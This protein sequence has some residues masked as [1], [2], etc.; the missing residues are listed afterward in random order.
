MTLH[1]HRATRTDVLADALAELLA[2]PL[3][4]PFAEEVVV[5]PAKGVERWLTQ[6]LS[7]RLGAGP[8]GSDGVCAGVRFLNPRSLVA[9]LTGTERDDPWDPD[10]SVW[11]L[12]SVIDASL[13]EP[14]CALLAR[15]LGHG[16][17]GEQG[18]LRRN[19]RYS[20]ARRIAGLFASYALQ[21][22]QLLV[23]WREGRDTD[24]AGKPL[25]E[26]LAWQ[27][28]L[29][30]RLLQEYDDG[31][32]AGPPD[33]RHRRAVDAI[34]AGNDLALPSRLSMFGH[35][36]MATTELALLRAVGE[37]R[38]V[39]L[40]LPQPSPEGWRRVAAETEDGPVRRRDDHSG[41][42][43]AHPLLA[44]LGRD[45][46]ELRRSIP[47]LGPLRDDELSTPDGPAVTLLA[48]LQDQ[49]RRDEVGA[50]PGPPDD[51]VQ[52]HA[53][54]GPGRQVE[55]LR[56]VLVGLL[57]DDPTLEPRDI[58][59]M[60]P[61][62]EAYAP[63]FSAAFGLAEAAG[64]GG[65]PGHQL[66]VRLADRGLA[67]TNPL[68]ALA[69]ALVRIA[70]GRATASEVLDLAGTAPVR[71]RFGI[72]DD[73]LA[74]LTGWVERSGVRW[75]LTADLRAPYG[76]EG[77]EENTWAL[78]LDR[79]LLGAATAEDGTVL[80]GRL[81]L[82]DVGSSSIDLAGRLAELVDRLEDGVVALR[83]ATTVVEWVDAL[84]GS[85][86]ALGDVRGR[87]AWMAAQLD[88]EL[89]SVL[90]ASEAGGGVHLG[91]ADVRTLLELRLEPRPTRANFRT[92]HLTVAT[93]VPMRSVP[94][95]VVCLLGLDDGVFPRTT[96]P[97]GDDALARDPITG[98]R[99]ARS[100]DRQL[101]L[102]AVLAARDTLV[103]T[104]TGA[105]ISSNQERPP[106]VPLAELLDAVDAVEPDARERVVRR[107]P[108]QP[109]DPRNFGAQGNEPFSFDRAALD[110]AGVLVGERRR[111]RSFLA[112]P[113]PLSPRPDLALADLQAFFRSPVRGFLRQ[114][115]DVV[116]HD[117]YDEPRDAMPVKLEGLEEWAIGD[118]VLRRVLESP[119]PQSVL[120]A[121]LL[122]G[123][124]PPR[125][126]GHR[127]M[128]EVCRRVQE[129]RDA[130]AQDRTAEPTSLDVTIDLGASRRLTGVVP[131]VRDDRLVRVV[132]SKLAPKHRFAAWLDLL[133][134]TVAFPD[135]SWTAITYGW[136]KK[137]SRQGVASSLLGPLDHRAREQ[138]LDLVETYDRG[139]CE[140]LPL[141]ARS[142]AAWAKARKDGKDPLREAAWAW[143]DGN[144][145]GEQS[146]PEHVLVHGRGA[147]LER[148]LGVPLADERWVD[149]E[150][151]RLGQYA[152]KTWRPLLA[153]EQGKNL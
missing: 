37:V 100:E 23:D 60:C 105:N 2:T 78:G 33:E 121:E 79:V 127:T 103:I 140:P 152:Q 110:A 143:K 64:G 22:P 114:G 136:F 53:C 126:L 76:L 104:Y 27:P 36:R 135:R 9:L 91:L 10:R 59:V 14:W 88:R 48:R 45:S 93:L 43:L 30:R 146:D 115:L 58:L 62:V 66:R 129:L 52:V 16:V 34:R 87:D 95:R 132:Y 86:R 15:H 28:E 20:V 49:L 112:S 151:T 73:D 56:E 119:D 5:V 24:G 123:E 42:L 47:L 13:D 80:G 51:S 147:E 26:D 46:R 101:L 98:E 139:L 92:G 21:R 57:Q 149:E 54:H 82:D 97:D 7:H 3:D 150:P 131:D 128:E 63:L 39:H 67:G 90:D 102:D 40:W 120:T 32:A 83:T 72:D 18:E 111:P 138:L 8:R 65:H 133:A 12:L 109:F 81:P 38:E 70:G 137:G 122:R 6:R 11:P 96:T 75:G 29:W 68:L 25:A 41:R 130:S 99:D 153:A 77:F 74:E 145:P 61:D 117:E 35:T 1:L 148:L 84:R 141:F 19:R 107:H 17:T 108:L 144:F 125:G 31:R 113:L 142:S 85:V 44:S 50:H 134:L 55:V 94:H 118:R 4:D 89:E 116:T 69:G 124:L 71:R 106:A